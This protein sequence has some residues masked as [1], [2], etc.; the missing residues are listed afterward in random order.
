MI[1]IN[2]ISLESIMILN[3]IQLDAGLTELSGDPT[4]W[5]AGSAEGQWAYMT[6]TS[7]VYRWRSA[8]SLWVAAEAYSAGTL[9][10]FATIVGTEDSTGLTALGYTVNTGGGGSVTTA[11]IGGESYVAL[12]TGGV[13]TQTCNLSRSVTSGHG[14]Y[15]AGKLQ[16]TAATGASQSHCMIPY[17]RNGSR[18]VWFNGAAAT[19]QARFEP[20]AMFDSSGNDLWTASVWLEV[21]ILTSG[22]AYART[23]H[24]D[25]FAAIGGP[26]CSSTTSTD[27]FIGDS[28]STSSATVNLRA[29]TTWD[30]AP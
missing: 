6:G 10:R 18:V 2:G 5:A 15:Y 29:F 8:D 9:T 4:A 23:D 11:T 19:N 21:L 1:I 14:H 12:N 25:W 20:A 16:V 17:M 7:A 28:S 24:G 22:T 27:E 30:I 26:Q 13:S 3:G